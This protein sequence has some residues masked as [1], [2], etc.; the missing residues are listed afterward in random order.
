MTDLLLVP[1]QNSNQY[2]F[3]LI[4]YTNEWLDSFS[5]KDCTYTT[6]PNFIETRSTWFSYMNADGM[7]YFI[8]ERMMMDSL[9][10]I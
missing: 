5:H 7:I 6:E 8:D 2:I 1:R 3:N 10:I 4:I 9:F